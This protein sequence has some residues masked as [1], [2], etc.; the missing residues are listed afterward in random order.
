LQY[1]PL[2]SYHS[3]HRSGGIPTSFPL[4]SST[5]KVN[6]VTQSTKR[7]LRNLSGGRAR[8]EV[9]NINNAA[10]NLVEI[11]AD[12][13]RS[14]DDGDYPIR[15]Y[16]IGMGDLVK[17]NLGT[18]Q[19]TSESILMRVANDVRSPDYISTQRE[20]RYYFARTA[21]DVGAAFEQLQNQ[22]IRLSK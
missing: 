8:A 6:G 10:R 19:E 13:A 12:A 14:D 2:T 16:T 1:L 3:H 9:W 5:L 21:A 22:I 15:I 20:G 7:Y 17:M 11:I 4:A 18:I